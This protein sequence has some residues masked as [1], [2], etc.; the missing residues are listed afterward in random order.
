[1]NLPFNIKNGDIFMRKLNNLMGYV[2]VIEAPVY[3]K[4]EIIT[5]ASLNG[6]VF[7]L[8]V[9]PDER[10]IVGMDGEYPL[11]IADY[12][13]QQIW[14]HYT[15]ENVFNALLRD[16]ELPNPSDGYKWMIIAGAGKNQYQEDV[17][18]N[19]K[20]GQLNVNPTKDFNGMNIAQPLTLPLWGS[21]EN[22]CAIRYT[23]RKD[24]IPQMIKTFER[25]NNDEEFEAFKYMMREL[26]GLSPSRIY[27]T[28]DDLHNIDS[29]GSKVIQ[30]I[31][32]IY[33]RD[34]GDLTPGSEYL[35]NGIE[36]IRLERNSRLHI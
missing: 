8:N 13:R 3:Q 5:S 19:I 27:D 30:Y 31:E 23:C 15:H 11:I 10:D 4:A 25:R 1:M 2:G 14:Q 28:K 29:L 35:K 32:Q 6:N 12:F 7:S 20:N 9:T 18:I 21:E 33:D 24:L 17:M 26:T 22:K 16:I 34:D 36:K